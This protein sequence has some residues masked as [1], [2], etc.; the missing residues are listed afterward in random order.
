MN[1]RPPTSVVSDESGSL[2]IICV[3]LNL[4]VQQ[5]LD[6]AGLEE[7]PDFWDINIEDDDDIPIRDLTKNQ[8]LFSDLF[9]QSL[10]NDVQAAGHAARL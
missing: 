4:N 1:T 9:C 6:L 8:S 5:D 2:T 3:P 7:D 10:A